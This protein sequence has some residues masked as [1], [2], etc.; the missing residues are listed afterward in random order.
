MKIFL[1]GWEKNPTPFS[2]TDKYHLLVTRTIHGNSF[3]QLGCN[4]E[5]YNIPSERQKPLSHIFAIFL[6]NTKHNTI[7][8]NLGIYD[9]IESTGY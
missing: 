7:V 8:D 1:G 4:V 9:R 3:F 6:Q 2:G 5:W